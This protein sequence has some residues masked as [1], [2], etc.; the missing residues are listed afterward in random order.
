MPWSWKRFTILFL[1][2]AVFLLVGLVFAWYPSSVI[3][4]LEERLR[5][6]GLPQ[7]EKDW[8]QGSLSWWYWA[9]I[10]TYEP[11]SYVLIAIGLVII[12]YSIVYSSFSIW[13]ELGLKRIEQTKRETVVT[14]QQME[15]KPI[16][17]LYQTVRIR[18]GFPVAAGILAIVSSCMSI[19][20]SVLGI[21]GFVSTLSHS[22]YSP[23]Y[24]SLFMGIFG[25]VA[26]AFGVTGGIMSLRRRNFILALIG[27]CL[28]I[29]QGFITIL[30]MGLEGTNA[31]AYSLLVGS[32]LI[33]LSVLSLIFI[34]ISNKEFS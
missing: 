14:G 12:A 30:A 22:Y 11:L 24:W 29:L 26:F 10:T 19:I 4:G 3:G 18:T 5:Q 20:F 15:K 6:G 32:P 34:A 1:A 27:A 2:G 25:L 23:Y 7:T 31:W 9:R 17:D 28:L 21:M 13:R 33:V 16:P 8:I